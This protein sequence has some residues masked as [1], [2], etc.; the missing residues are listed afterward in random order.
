[1]HFTFTRQ[2]TADA[3]M[4]PDGLLFASKEPIAKELVEKLLANTKVRE[5]MPEGKPLMAYAYFKKEYAEH[6]L[7]VTTLSYYTLSLCYTNADADSCIYYEEPGQKKT[8]DHDAIPAGLRVI[9]YRETLDSCVELFRIDNGCQECPYKGLECLEK[10]VGYRPWVFRFAYNRTDPFA[11]G[12]TDKGNI[13]DRDEYV[14]QHELRG[15]SYQAL[16][17]QFN[18]SSIEGFVFLPPNKT[19]T[20][21]SVKMGRPL[22]PPMHH[23]FF[24]AE[25][26]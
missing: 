22:R 15:E 9:N 6:R 16:L 12:L 17:K 7:V 25:K 2:L 3:D 14:K 5:S 21:N 19:T 20:D 1:M 24:P 26:T 10:N 23:R 11:I 8:K 18:K 13:T 4:K